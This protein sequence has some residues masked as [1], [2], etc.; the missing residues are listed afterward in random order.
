MEKKG[1]PFIY[2]FGIVCLL[3]T[4]CK[5]D[6]PK[7][8]IEKIVESKPKNPITFPNYW[9]DPKVMEFGREAPRSDFKPF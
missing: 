1:N 9:K 8:T 2:L 3:T 4:H 7:Q 5:Q 6:V